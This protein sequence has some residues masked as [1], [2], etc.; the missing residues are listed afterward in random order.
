V[1]NMPAG[2]HRDSALVA[3]QQLADKTYGRGKYASKGLTDDA[4]LSS[5]R[6]IE[7]YN[8][9][10]TK[11]ENAK[12]KAL[13]TGVAYEVGK[14][15]QL[16]EQTLLERIG[17][18][19]LDQQA[20]VIGAAIKAFDGELTN[21]Q[22]RIGVGAIT[23]FGDGVVG[24]AEGAESLGKTIIGVAQFTRD[25][26]T[27]DPAA[28][29]TAAK[30]GE[31]LGKLMVG[32]VRVFSAANDYVESVGAATNVGDYGK[33]LRDVSWLGQQMNNR[34]ESMSPEEKTRL[35]TKLAVENLGSMATGIAIDKLAKSI[36]ITEALEALG[37]EASTM[38][39]GV[40]DKAKKVISKIADD[41]LPQPMGVTPDGRLMPIPRET[42]EH[43]MFMKGDK[44]LP[45]GIKPSEQVSLAERMN[46]LGFVRPEVV[47]P[48]SVYE[49]AAIQG[50]SS[51]IVDQ[52][53]QIVAE[54]LQKAFA[55]VGK[56]DPR[57]HGTERTYGNQLHERMRQNLLN[58]ADKTIHPEASY[59]KNSPA[60]WGKLGT[61][62]V[63]ISIG[64]KA[65][66]FVSL[67]LKTLKATPSAHQ[68]RGWVRNLPPLADGSVPP[69]LY[70]KLPKSGE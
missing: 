62:R 37:A 60:D 29:E 66:P 59:L 36:K 30:A 57:I 21:Q 14:P 56:Y 33:P 11:Q 1:T 68:E 41:L 6:P 43:V 39:A 46:S 40:H 50:F 49:A 5:N 69:R 53:L 44:G 2:P 4:Q 54:A 55:R 63:D 61:S 3:V 22:F 27:N 31:S 24:L 17:A 38:G 28:I 64:D 70:L 34:W 20:Q 25:V 47:V 8:Y 12:V 52:N 45:Q 13:E 48:K 7:D 35:V 23:G 16:T 65:K 42:Q 10:V 32:G 18:L 26:M 15:A 51:E 67:C 9:Q 19:P 58:I